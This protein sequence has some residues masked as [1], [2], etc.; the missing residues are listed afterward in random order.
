MQEIFL[1]ILRTWKI[2]NSCYFIEITKGSQV[3][4]LSYI[5]EVVT[6][7]WYHKIHIFSDYMMYAYYEKYA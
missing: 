7:L 6:F 4:I 1:I 3:K 2:G 5:T